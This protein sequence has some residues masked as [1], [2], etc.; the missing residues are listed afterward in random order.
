MLAGKYEAGTNR[1]EWYQ[2]LATDRPTASGSPDGTSTGIATAQVGGVLALNAPFIHE[3]YY[4]GTAIGT[5][6][7]GGT[8]VMAPLA[9]LYS[10]IAPLTLFSREGSFTDAF[11][12]CIAVFVLCSE[13]LGAP[14]RAATIAK[15]KPL[16]GIA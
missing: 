13:V 4:D 2:L 8:P 10:G 9:T 3:A 11:A 7:N 14:A 12:G 5:A 1:R 6:L 15:R 16:G